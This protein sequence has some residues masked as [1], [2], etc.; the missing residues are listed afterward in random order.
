M[1]PQILF[2][3]HRASPTHVLLDYEA[4]SLAHSPM[5]WGLPPA[6]Q[7][8]I[9]ARRHSPQSFSGDCSHTVPVFKHAAASA[10]HSQQDECC[11]TVQL[12]VMTPVLPFSLL[13]GDVVSII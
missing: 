1:V 6:A 3:K 8:I 12:R 5:A 2:A 13:P 7:H 4:L 11:H 9:R 10:P